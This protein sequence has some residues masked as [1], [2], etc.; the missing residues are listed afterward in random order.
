MAYEYSCSACGFQVQ[1][2]EDDEL[3]ELVQTH[4]REKHDMDVDESDVRD[5]WTEVPSADD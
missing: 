1:S 3:I 4:G 2:D 5:G